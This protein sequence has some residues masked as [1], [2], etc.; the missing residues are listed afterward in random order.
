MAD[1]A[2]IAQA[3]IDRQLQVS[4]DGRVQYEGES[5]FY[6]V[7]CDDVIPHQ[8]REAVPGVKHCV[9]CAAELEHLNR[10]KV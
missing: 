6:C 8:R 3:A 10:H 7:E 1:E 9:N 4:I 2:D 5:E